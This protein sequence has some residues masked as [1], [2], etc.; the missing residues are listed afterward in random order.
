MAGPLDQS[1]SLAP[2][3]LVAVALVNIMR[4]ETAKV[5]TLSSSY[6]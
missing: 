3:C 5:F 1:T 2:S 6:R 4:D